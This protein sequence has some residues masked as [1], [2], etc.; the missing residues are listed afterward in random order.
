MD[1]PPGPVAR[2]AE[3]EL[4]EVLA[5]VILLAFV[6]VTVTSVVV[7][8]VTGVGQEGTGLTSAQTVGLAMQNATSWANPAFAFVLLAGV[9]LVW[10]Q[11]KIWSAEIE[12]AG[13]GEAE[14]IEDD[15]DSPILVA[16]FD[17]LL[18]A[19][20]LASW[21][22][23][24]LAVVLAAAADAV[25]ASFLLYRGASVGGGTIWSNHLE[26][27]GLG[28]A[29]WLLAGTGM[30]AAL[31]VRTRVSLEFTQAE[32]AA[33]EE[34]RRAG[35]ARRT[36]LAPGVGTVGAPATA[37]VTAPGNGGLVPSEVEVVEVAVVELDEADIEP[38]DEGG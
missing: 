1:A 33:E 32:D 29:T 34:E 38:T 8:I 12:L 17:H 18:R 9:G 15:A 21:A 3:W 4:P 2:H 5:A 26:A 25:A 37:E 13:A 35:R 31:Y 36:L 22:V 14:D 19:K 23:P 20:S 7:G 10:W 30:V 16:A 11:V 6:V 24:L 28:L 27:I